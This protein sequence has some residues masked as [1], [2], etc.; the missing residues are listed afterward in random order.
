[1]PSRRRRCGGGSAIRASIPLVFPAAKL[2]GF[3]I[4]AF[5]VA[6]LVQARP[7]GPGPGRQALPVGRRPGSCDLLGATRDQRSFAPGMEPMR[8]GHPEYVATAG[9][10]EHLLD[11]AD[12]I[13]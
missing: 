10:A 13:D 3:E 1:M 9:L 6:P 4:G 7:L 12:A 2:T 5:H 11:L 8:A